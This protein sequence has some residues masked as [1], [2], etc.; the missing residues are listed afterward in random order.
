MKL[1][2]SLSLVAI[3]LVVQWGRLQFTCT[4]ALPNSAEVQ[5]LFFQHA[6][7]SSSLAETVK[8]GTGSVKRA[9][10]VSASLGVAIQKRWQGI[11]P[12][13]PVGGR[14]RV[15][16]RP[17]PPQPSKSAGK[18]GEST[19]QVELFCA[20]ARCA[21]DRY[22]GAPQLCVPPRCEGGGQRWADIA[23]GVVGP[24]HDASDEQLP[25]LLG[26]LE[27]DNVL[28]EALCRRQCL[29]QL[30]LHEVC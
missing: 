19:S 4:R 1:L 18:L 25:S 24:W 10:E 17:K 11:R 16:R 29:L 13:D 5:A 26:I 12:G 27:L 23:Q 2:T 28:Q 9:H 8:L 7:R 30:L 20:E 21:D 6:L 22:G 14:G 3:Q 15:N